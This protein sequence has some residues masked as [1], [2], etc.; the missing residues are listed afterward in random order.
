MEKELRKLTEMARDVDR[1]ET[2]LKRKRDQR[3]RHALRLVE[4]GKFSLRKVAIH[5][6]VTNPYLV[7]LRKKLNG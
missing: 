2:Q 5:A 7:Q 3:N 4:S 1:L 6:S